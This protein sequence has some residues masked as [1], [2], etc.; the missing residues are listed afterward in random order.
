MEVCFLSAG[1]LVVITGFP[2]V[3]TIDGLREEAGLLFDVD[4]DETF[5]GTGRGIAASVSCRSALRSASEGR[6][7]ASDIARRRT[8]RAASCDAS[9]EGARGKG[10]VRPGTAKVGSAA[11]GGT[12]TGRGAGTGIGAGSGGGTGSVAETGSKVTEGNTD[13]GESA[14]GSSMTGG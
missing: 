9:G 10:S 7:P 14:T 3:S 13:A 11:G 1:S 8:L 12:R 4:A 6:R 5:R 2:L